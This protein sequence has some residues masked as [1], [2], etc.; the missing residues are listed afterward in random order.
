MIKYRDPQLLDCVIFPQPLLGRRHFP[1]KP[2]E[3]YCNCDLNV[4][5]LSAGC[6]LSAV[7]CRRQRTT[8]VRCRL[9][10]RGSFAVHAIAFHAIF[11]FPCTLTLV[12]LL[13]LSYSSEISTNSCSFPVDIICPSVRNVGS[14]DMP[15]TL[16]A[17]LSTREPWRRSESQHNVCTVAP[18]CWSPSVSEILRCAKKTYKHKLLQQTWHESSSEISLFRLE[19]VERCRKP[20]FMNRFLQRD[21]THRQTSPLFIQP[22]S[23]LRDQHNNGIEVCHR[24]VQLMNDREISQ[25]LWVVVS[26]RLDKEWEDYV[27]GIFKT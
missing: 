12:P 17:L 2:M 22:E 18:V 15:Y 6:K 24:K 10:F 27:N 1:L 7:V 3:S 21:E 4:T 8:L 16:H 19:W 23:Q 14:F 5:F 11:T 20:G 13:C 9:G 26:T 25:W